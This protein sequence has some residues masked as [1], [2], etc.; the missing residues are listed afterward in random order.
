MEKIKIISYKFL[1]SMYTWHLFQVVGGRCYI[2]AFWPSVLVNRAFGV[3]LIFVQFIIPLFI[4]MYCYGRIVWVLTRRIATNVG[5]NSSG[6]KME[7][8]IRD[9]FLLARTNTIKTFLLVGLCFIICWSN[10]QI[11]FL[12]Y[13][14][15][16]D[17]NFNGTYYKFNVSMVFVNCTVNPF[18][19]L[20]K[21][22]DYQ[23]ALRQLCGCNNARDNEESESKRSTT[24]EMI[25]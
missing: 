18:I 1:S 19:Y 10:D 14:L 20:V 25:M 3:F 11:F 6:N 17:V 22:K 15:G 13:N 2:Y 7:A 9:K 8:V 4:L 16:Y 21:Y 24:S 12:M 23:Q 5:S